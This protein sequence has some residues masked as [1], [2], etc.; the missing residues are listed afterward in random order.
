MAW[1]LTSSGREYNCGEGL[2][3]YFHPASGNTHML[4]EFA[5]GVLRELMAGP[6]TASLLAQCKDLDVDGTLTAAQ[7]DNVLQELEEIY[8][9]EH[10]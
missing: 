6:S 8:L 7:V 1:R 2:V 4:N 9:V 10:V 5:A 3:V